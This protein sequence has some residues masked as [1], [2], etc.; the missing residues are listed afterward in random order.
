MPGA[1]T[2]TSTPAATST[3]SP[4]F[5]SLSGIPLIE[6]T[7]VTTP[8]KPGLESSAFTIA[9]DSGDSGRSPELMCGT[10]A[11]VLL[12]TEIRR[13]PLLSNSM[14]LTPWS[15]F[16]DGRPV[17]TGIGVSKLGPSRMLT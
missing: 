3:I 9:A 6:S 16:E 17:I 2:V 4:D 5:W 10:P 7:Y 13:S 15:W 14:P 12:P 11:F 8:L 1:W